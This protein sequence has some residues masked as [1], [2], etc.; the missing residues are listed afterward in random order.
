MH[1]N[2]LWCKEFIHLCQCGGVSQ[3]MGQTTPGLQVLMDAHL[4]TSED[5]FMQTALMLC[6]LQGGE[7]NPSHLVYAQRSCCQAR[8]TNVTSGDTAFSIHAQHS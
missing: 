3:K 6:V 5:K 8:V 7:E 4:R 1:S 2:V